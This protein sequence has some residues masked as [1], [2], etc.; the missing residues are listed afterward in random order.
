MVPCLLECSNAWCRI[1][2]EKQN[3]KGWLLRSEIWGVYSDE[4]V[5]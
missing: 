2:T 3:I 4:V 5:Q 1:E